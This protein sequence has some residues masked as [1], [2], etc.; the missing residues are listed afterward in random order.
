MNNDL[1]E[2][3]K[4]ELDNFVKESFPVNIDFATKLG[5][6]KPFE[7]LIDFEK[8]KDFVFINV[9]NFIKHQTIDDEDRVWITTRIAYILGEYFS[10]KY[11]GYWAVNENNNSI[12]YGEYSLFTK[13]PTTGCLIPINIFRK[14]MSFLDKKENRNLIQLIDEIEMK[15]K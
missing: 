11:S 14:V 5:V 8:L 9:H 7:I 2:K 1:I 3:R 6:D 15:I 10:I 12:N 13:S 4:S